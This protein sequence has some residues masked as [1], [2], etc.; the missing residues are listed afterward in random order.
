MVE[1]LDLVLC[2]VTCK[3]DPVT[4]SF[5]TQSAH[6]SAI[7]LGYG[8]C[9]PCIH[10]LMELRP[11]QKYVKIDKEGSAMEQRVRLPADPLVMKCME[12]A[13]SPCM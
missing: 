1:R 5:F 10:L 4:D 12:N 3:Q 6:G 13:C 2:L 9:L 8:M 11:S 7:I